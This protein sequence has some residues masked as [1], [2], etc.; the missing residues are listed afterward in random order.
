MIDQGSKTIRII[1]LSSST[2]TWERISFASRVQYNGD[3][4]YI[5]EMSLVSIQN[6]QSNAG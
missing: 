6:S 2:W 4:Q 5:G 1:V 3:W